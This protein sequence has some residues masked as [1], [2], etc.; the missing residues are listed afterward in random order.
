MRAGM[1]YGR[2]DS[3]ATDN[4]LRINGRYFAKASKIMSVR[5]KSGPY[6]PTVAQRRVWRAPIS[7]ARWLWLGVALVLYILCLVW[8]IYAVRTQPF[9]GPFADPLRLFGILAFVLVLSTA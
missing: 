3:C 2:G 6:K 1:S 7:N 8:Y 9:A 4:L 5:D